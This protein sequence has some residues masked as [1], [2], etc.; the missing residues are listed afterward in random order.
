MPT[1]PRMIDRGRKPRL[2]A[3]PHACETH[4]HIYGPRERYPHHPGR[5]PDLLADL[6]TFLAML[7][8]IGLERAVIVQPSLYAFDNRATLDAVAAMGLHRARGVAVCRPTV[9]DAELRDLDARGIRGLRFFLL[10]DDV[11]LDVIEPMARRSADLGWHVVVQGHG[12]WLVEAAPVLHRLPCP[13]VID[14]LGRTPAAAGTDHAG[15]RALLGLLETGNCWVKISAPYITSD[16]GPPTY[17]DCGPRIQALVETRPDRLLWA[18]NWPHPNS[19]VD[20]KPDE[21]DCLDLLLDWVPDETTRRM[22]LA[23]NPATLYGF[24]G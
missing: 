4:S 12:D 13:V 11:G 20:A 1:Q 18:A 21:A 23:D 16:V 2:L 14:H 5:T 22:I 15:F 8:R 24:E 7:E 6:P 19:P 3:P 17:A 9:T 10:V